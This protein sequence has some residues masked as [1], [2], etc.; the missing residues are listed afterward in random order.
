MFLV[1]DQHVLCRNTEHERAF[2]VACCELSTNTEYEM[3]SLELRPS[4]STRWFFQSR[5]LD[6]STEHEWIVFLW[7]TGMILPDG[8]PTVVFDR[9]AVGQLIEDEEAEESDIDM[10]GE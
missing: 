10:T 8:L 1:V 6:A 5:V 3:I 7:P 4:C 2:K 9:V